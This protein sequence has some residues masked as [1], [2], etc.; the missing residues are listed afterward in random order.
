MLWRCSAYSSASDDRSPRIQIACA[1]RCCKSGFR[2]FS[3]GVGQRGFDRHQGIRRKR[4]GPRRYARLRRQGLTASDGSADDGFGYS[5]SVS[6]DNFV[7]GARRSD[8]YGENSGAAYLFERRADGS[9]TEQKL[10]TSDGSVGSVLGYSV[11]VSGGVVVVGASHNDDNG[12]DSGSAYV[13]EGI[14]DRVSQTTGLGIASAPRTANL[15]PSYPNLF[16]PTTTLRYNN[17]SSQQ[18]RLTIH[19]LSGQ[20]VRT[21]VDERVSAGSHG[22]VWDGRDAT[23]K[24]VASGVYLYRLTFDEQKITRRMTLVR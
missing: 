3:I 1:G 2:W 24:A 8:R 11:S 19:N 4:R 7:I 6:G 10:L 21:L 18:I 9:W 22:I 5:V 15:E 20:V 23:G 12:S 13:F 17:H 16:N 14:Y